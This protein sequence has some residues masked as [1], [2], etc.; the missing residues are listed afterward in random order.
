V[1]VGNSFIRTVLVKKSKSLWTGVVLHS[2]SNIILMG[3]F[4]EMTVHKGYAAYIVSETGIITGMACI[5]VALVF[6]KI[7]MKRLPM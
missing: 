7:Q 6:W 2:S 5:T 3:M 1:I 4:W